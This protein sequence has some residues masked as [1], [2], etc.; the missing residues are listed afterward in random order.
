MYHEEQ[1]LEEVV[2]IHNQQDQVVSKFH[3]ENEIPVQVHNHVHV[4]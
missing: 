1:Y 4:H 2:I 3:I